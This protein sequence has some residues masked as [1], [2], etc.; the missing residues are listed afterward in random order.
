MLRRHAVEMLLRLTPAEWKKRLS[1]HLG[2]PHV[3]WSLRQLKHFGFVPRQVLDV[4]AF[5]GSWAR[6]CLDVF[7]Q[8]RITCIEP[9]DRQ[10]P[11]L[12]ALVAEK[13]NIQVIQTLLGRNSLL[14]VPFVESGSGSS[15]FGN[16][17]GSGPTKPMA[18]I[19]SLIG[20]GRFEP[21]DLIKLDVQGYEIEVLEGWTNNF[22]RCQIIQC[23]ISLLPLVPGGPLLHELV[24]Y[25]GRRGF[26][27]FDVTELIRSPSD[28][29][30]WQIDAL[31]C[32][33]DSQFRQERRW[34][35]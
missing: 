23:E 32:R 1:I 27:M 12:V 30:V 17:K 34:R 8:A 11:V 35:R 2:A 6:T 33:M 21:P 13:P 15:V 4:G 26:V 22:D 3:Q 28:G 25:L 9:Q 10:Q 19:D 20:S 7:P 16:A 18:T 31:F 14:Q 24:A 5:E 29:A